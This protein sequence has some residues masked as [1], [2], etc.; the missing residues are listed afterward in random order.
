MEERVKGAWMR[1]AVDRVSPVLP[2]C[3]LPVTICQ[4]LLRFARESRLKVRNARAARTLLTG[5]PMSKSRVAL[6]VGSVLL[7]LVLGTAVAD[8]MVE[9]DEER[10]ADVA[11][12]LVRENAEMRVDGLLAWSDPD[13]QPV[14]VT[15]G[16]T[17]SRIDDSADLPDA[18][19]AALGAFDADQP[20][21]VVQRDVSISSETATV[22]LRA[23]A[24]G[25]RVDVTITLRREGQGFLISGVRVL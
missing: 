21:E 7:F 12:V 6:W 11:D 16:R 15:E 1:G 13:R 3:S 22:S 18:L 10:L 23:R 19:H 17:R 2:S 4:R 14:Y 25:E 24:D 9:T 8:A 5:L 20:V